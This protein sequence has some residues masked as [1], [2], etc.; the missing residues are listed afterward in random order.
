MQTELDIAY[1][2]WN[3]LRLDILSQ[4]AIAATL[5]HL[6]IDHGP[7][8]IS[9]LACDDTAIAELNADFRGKA[10]ATNV[11]SW[12]AEDLTPPALPKPDPDGTMPLG[13]IA[14]SF[15]TCAREAAV[16]GKPL[17]VHVT[18]L[19]VH[20]TLHL[21]GYDHESD[22]DAS[23]MERLEVE[24]LGKLGHRDPYS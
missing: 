21:L 10:Q 22:T 19:I 20:G 2:E 12:P 6:G 18:H 16:A 3:V 5:V 24:I 14:I 23:V 17:D 9:L 1:S 11:L 15:D 4:T 8:E 7:V 13:D